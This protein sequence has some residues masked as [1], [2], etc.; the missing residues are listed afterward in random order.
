MFLFFLEGVSSSSS[1]GGSSKGGGDLL[2]IN[3]LTAE[4]KLT[5]LALM[6][7]WPYGSATWRPQPTVDIGEKKNKRQEREGVSE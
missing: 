5:S 7:S 6:D 2:L 4:I 1:G 3:V